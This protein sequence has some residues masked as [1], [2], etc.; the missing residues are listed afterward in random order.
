MIYEKTRDGE[1]WYDVYSRLVKERVVFLSGEEGINSDDATALSAT[2]LYLDHQSKTKPISIYIN[3]PGGS[4][5]DGL[6][7]IYDTMQYIKA[8]IK[9]VCMGEACSAGAVLLA[10]G[11]KGM[12]LAFENSTI[13][14]HQLQ[15]SGISGTQSEIERETARCKRVN[16]KILQ[17]IAAHSGQSIE[18]V[19]DDVKHDF[20]L[21]AEEA[22]EYGLID[23]LVKKSKILPKITPKKVQ[24]RRK[25]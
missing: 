7:T 9:T 22:I 1:M 18:K 11:T 19:K 14:I 21:T 10:A 6:F 16:D 2:L 8:P 12:R 3:S 13:M 15:V 23:G 20:Y 17:T 4:V 24:G 5:S 25:A